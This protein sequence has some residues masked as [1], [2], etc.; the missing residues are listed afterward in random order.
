M[1]KSVTVSSTSPVTSR[2]LGPNRSD[3]MPAK[4][5]TMP[6]ATAAGSMKMPAWSGG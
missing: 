4:G 1:L 2:I 3:S 5:D 6:T